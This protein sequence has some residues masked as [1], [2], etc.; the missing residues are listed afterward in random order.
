[1]KAE[2]FS[3]ARENLKAAQILFDNDLFNAVAN[4]TYYAAFQAAIAALIDKGITN[5][6]YEHKWVQSTFNNELI[7]KRKI[8][9]SSIK[10][11]LMDLQRMRNKA[12]YTSDTISKK[13]ANRQLTK[14][15]EFVEAIKKEMSK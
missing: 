13:I 10:S 12:D 2:F 1:M 11:Y 5:S 15:K 7:N 14:A 3:K 9:P 8:Y 4:R 6:K